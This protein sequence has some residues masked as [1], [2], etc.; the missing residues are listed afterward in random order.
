M[1]IERRAARALLISDDAVL[2][3]QGC[4]PARPDDGTW[5]LTPGGGIDEGES[6][7]DAVVREVLEET[8]LTLRVADAGPV[9]A[10]R[11]ADFLFDGGAYHQ[12]E[13]FFAIEVERF[14]PHG[15]G[16][17]PIEQRA[18]LAYRWWTVQELE[19]TSDVVYPTEMAALLRAVLAG[20]VTEPFALS[21]A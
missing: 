20:S 17:E 19:S 14:E 7:E 16:W 4:D 12:S 1:T 8:G 21:G 6:R 2:L 9:V 13:W 11:V 5:W 18:L 15:A 10:T 3:I